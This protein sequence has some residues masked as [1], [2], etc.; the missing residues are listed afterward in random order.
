MAY[1]VEAFVFS[2]ETEYDASVFRQELEEL[3]EELV[4]SSG[5]SFWTR[6]INEDVK[7]N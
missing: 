1:S 4:S 6:I 5:R 7:G 2:F 3:I